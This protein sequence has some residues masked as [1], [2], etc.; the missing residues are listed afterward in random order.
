MEKTIKFLKKENDQRKQAIRGLK[1]N[2][3]KLKEITYNLES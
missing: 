1:D 3:Q 2:V